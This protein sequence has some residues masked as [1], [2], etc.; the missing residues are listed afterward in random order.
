MDATISC[1]GLIKQINDELQKN[2]NNA[3]RSQDLTMA[4]LGALIELNQ[5]EGKQLSL[6]ELERRLHLAQSTSAGIVSRLEEKR[7]IE[8]F[9]DAS[10]RRIK[11][12][13]ITS[14]GL[15]RIK[16]AEQEMNRAENQLLSSLT[17]TERSIFYTL[18]RKVRDS[19][20]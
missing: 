14:S 5:A 4:Q 3:M 19:L 15:E 18:L 2:A 8:S 16:D 6:K 11:L 17:D 7:L 12:V 1:G 10:D 20:R 13:R 9:G